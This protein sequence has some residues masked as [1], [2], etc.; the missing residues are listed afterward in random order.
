MGFDDVTVKTGGPLVSICM[1]VY[2]GEKFLRQTLD[3]LVSQ[4]YKNI[5]IIILDNQSTDKTADICKAYIEKD[6]RIRFI[7]DSRKVGV[8][9]GHNRVAQ[10]ARGEYIMLACD[11]DIYDP[12]FISSLLP[13]FQKS[14]HIGLVYPHFD[15]IDGQGKHVADG[16]TIFLKQANTKAKNFFIY[17]FKRS[18][19]PTLF[20][21]FKAKFYKK[22]LPFF[23][24][25]GKTFDADNLFILRFLTLTGVHSTNKLLFHYRHRDRSCTVPHNY[26]KAS[27]LRFLYRINHQWLV[28]VHIFDIILRSSF[29]AITKL[30][31][32]VY[33]VIVFVYYCFIL[34]ELSWLRKVLKG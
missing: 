15:W 19:L 33:A 9:E 17:T 28:T 3:S 16:K 8:N 26:P 11:D 1:P 6:K 2:N 34:P 30:I 12:E 13:L 4:I 21:I 7:L 20:G 18:V 10:Y 23:D 27:I 5:E 24:V 32:I 25:G 31:L 22:A 29:A 14:K